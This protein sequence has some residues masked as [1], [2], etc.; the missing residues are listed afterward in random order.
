MTPTENI[1]E[2]IHS[3]LAL[4]F[5]PKHFLK[6]GTG[7][8][9][10]ILAIGFFLRDRRGD[11]PS[12]PLPFPESASQEIDHLGKMNPT[13]PTFSD[14]E[15]KITDYGA[16]PG[17]IFKNTQVFAD[18]IEACAKKN[19]TVVVP[20]GTWL[21]GAIHLK[22]NVRLY[23]QSG[24]EILFS[25]DPKDYLPVVETRFIGLDLW[26]YSPFI[27]AKDC[28]NIAITGEGTLNGQGE[29]WKPFFERQND[30]RK[31]LYEMS[32]TD[33]PVS[34]R[35]FGTEDDGLRPS[36]I[37]PFRCDTVLIQGV[38]IINSPMWT[39]HPLYSENVTVDSIRVQSSMHNS[40]GVVIDSS[41]RV[42]V[43]GSK[44]ETG[45]DAIAIKSG[46][47]KD[48]WRVGISSEDIVIRDN[49]VVM[50]HGGVSI[51]S[52]MSGGVRNVL[53]DGGTFSTVD[54]GFRLKTARGRGGTVENI[55]VQNT[56]F[57]NVLNQGIQI[58]LNYGSS[59]SKPQTDALPTVQNLLFSNIDLHSMQQSLS[60]EGLQDASI[61]HIVF[62]AI[63]ANSF[64]G[65]DIA[66]AE[67]VTIQNSSFKSEI[68]PLF[69]LENVKRFSFSE[70]KCRA[71]KDIYFALSGKDT[72]DIT[73]NQSKKCEFSKE[74]L[75][76][77]GI[78]KQ[79]AIILQ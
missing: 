68:A 27:Y 12:A 35:V 30:A 46:R 70:N 2:K 18:A 78:A 64:G 76:F 17:G 62:D 32:L 3:L 67:N 15:C 23:V 47:D 19:G 75:L 38:R 16:R 39:V 29:K 77:D 10:T 4:I 53:V 28:E 14:A 24:A 20:R 71:P 79:G 9:I 57:Q 45:D 42:L 41:K 34:K 5:H 66:Y 43:Q 72:A 36:F 69:L 31:R 6:F 25:A 50:A 52:E 13:L 48:G 51:G 40:D 74:S 54:R 60:L 8:L 49:E 7:L 21:T 61:K 63:T 37:Q 26:N 58:T 33:T 44:F 11:T 56:S 22:S 1:I 73:L 55:F 65:S 59:S